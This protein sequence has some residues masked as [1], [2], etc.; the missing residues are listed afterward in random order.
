MTSL[1]IA[2]I[3]FRR[4]FFLFNLKGGILRQIIEENKLPNKIFRYLFP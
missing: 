3:Y 4:V 2:W 1:K